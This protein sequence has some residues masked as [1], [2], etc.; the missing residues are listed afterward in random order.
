[1]IIWLRTLIAITTVSLVASS[2]GFAVG[3]GPI[4]KN[5]RPSSIP[6][7]SNNSYH[8]KAKV[9]D[10]AT[11]MSFSSNDLTWSEKNVTHVQ[12][13]PSWRLE[14]GSYIWEP[15]G[16]NQFIKIPLQEQKSTKNIPSDKLE[17]IQIEYQDL[18]LENPSLPSVNIITTKSKSPS[19]LNKKNFSRKNIFSYNPFISDNDYLNVS[20]SLWKKK[21]PLYLIKRTL[22]LSFDD[23][24]H[25][26]TDKHYS[27]FQRRFQKDLQSIE[28]IDLVVNKQV[29]GE[30]SE[31]IFK[32]ISCNFRLSYNNAMFMQVIT[33]H[34][35]N[36]IVFKSNDKIIIR[37][38]IGD[39]LRQ[40]NKAP[41]TA[42]LKEMIIF[43]PKSL[44]YVRHYRPVESIVFQH[45][46]QD[47]TKDL[48]RFFKNKDK[49]TK[50]S[51][52]LIHHNE[53][54][55]TP[56]QITPFADQ[57][58]R[59]QT[60]SRDSKRIIVKLPNIIPSTGKSFQY[61]KTKLSNISLK[62]KPNNPD[63]KSGFRL[64]RV[65][66]IIRNEKE[67]K[68]IFIVDNKK[69]RRWGGPFLNP[70]VNDKKFERIQINSFFPFENF[71]KSNPY[72]SNEETRSGISVQTSDNSFFRLLDS[73]EGL[74]C[75][76]W[77]FSKNSVATIKFPEIGPYN[78]NQNITL[79][80]DLKGPLQVNILDSP[81]T[82]TNTSSKMQFLL[83]K[84]R[85][86]ALIVK[87]DKSDFKGH[88]RGV[89]GRLVL[90][91][92]QKHD[93]VDP[94]LSDIFK[95][96]SNSSQKIL[97][98]ARLNLKIIFSPNKVSSD[99]H[100]FFNRFI[101]SELKFIPKQVTDKLF[102]KKFI[103]SRGVTVQ[104]KES[105][106]QWRTLINGLELEGKGK[107]IEVDWPV[108]A[109]LKEETHFHLGVTKGSDSIVS[110]KVIPFSGAN[111]LA[112][113]STMPNQSLPLNLAG[114]NVDRFKLHLKLVENRPFKIVLREMALFEPVMAN[115]AQAINVHTQWNG[116]VLTPYQ[117]NSKMASTILIKGRHLHATV[118]P[119]QGRSG[120]VQW[121]TQIDQKSHA[122]SWLKTKY[123]IPPSAHAFNPCWLKV[124]WVGKNK[125]MPQTICTNHFEG[126]LL[127]PVN[128][129]FT[130]D[131][132]E[133]IHWE[134]RI[135]LPQTQLPLPVS[136]DLEV[137]SHES[138]ETTSHYK[139][140]NFPLLKIRG[141]E[142]FPISLTNTTLD[143]GIHKINIDTFG[144]KKF[145]FLKNPYLHID[146]FS[147]Q[148]TNPHGKTTL[149][150][151]W[152]PTII[153]DPASNF[154]SINQTLKFLLLLL[155][156]SLLTWWLL[157]KKR[158]TIA[159]NRVEEN[160]ILIK[161]YGQQFIFFTKKITS[162]IQSRATLYNRLFG[163][164]LII[165]IGGMILSG[166]VKAE[167]IIFTSSSFLFLGVLC[168]EF[169]D[170]K[171]GKIPVI[172]YILSSIMFLWLLWLLAHSNQLTS[173]FLIPLL[174]L[175][176]FYIP[177]L[178]R[179]VA[180]LPHYQTQPAR[181]WIIIAGVTYF[182]GIIA[183]VCGAGFDSFLRILSV[184]HLA[185]VPYWGHLM[186]NIQTMV[187]DRSQSI[188]EVVYG[189]QENLYVTGFFVFLIAIA[190]LRFFELTIIT[191]Q[192]A[193][194]GFYL[195]VTG[196]ALKTKKLFKRKITE[197]NI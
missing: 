106:T 108:E 97:C 59:V 171:N 68:S 63:F 128:D 55:K 113:F 37:F 24:W 116:S 154:S 89:R 31:E 176:Y 12:E 52:I 197:Q 20:S 42:Y 66:K 177:W 111:R 151:V 150:Y 146:F 122:I 76:F 56:N 169:C 168:H 16:D 10:N 174:S 105:F 100:K 121:R 32:K 193:I 158:W 8:I 155:A 28:A 36:P 104:A 45:R 4:S 57:I 51:S 44:P 120:T 19:H 43:V 192:F 127:I 144:T 3:G 132:L 82:W 39:F 145:S 195:L 190:F 124:T 27:V 131:F 88:H 194:I 60:M 103:H 67:I 93:S 33:H 137:V 22:G 9:S 167:Y 160:S 17:E 62:F 141:E 175:A 91:T 78:T 81:V 188:A 135:G 134:A 96:Q 35:L 74:V 148:N 123:R 161:K 107:W 14:N 99:C 166:N 102:R 83:K 109:F 186:K 2:A 86:P 181:F 50:V 58:M 101:S 41:Q 189:A 143:L 112:S 84:G 73:E 136:F 29:M 7:A 98:E 156:I 138:N 6:S 65:R 40:H 173:R 126:R 185:I 191:E 75:D 1:M 178:S 149:E 163:F 26:S 164:T 115:E 21:K 79:N 15:G 147:F 117:P 165:L 94:L 129:S 13:N 54:L 46:N 119:E 87:A 38:T 170:T 142:I 49:Q 92:I 139:S 11:L 110:I 95:N 184:G 70:N 85:L 72:K 5:H 152:K 25:Y 64:Q 18:F 179:V 71:D 159:G 196:I 125:K 114:Q 153:P 187:E 48:V 172:V 53:T 80:W 162:F 90:K 118:L 180:S 61:E 30:E 34:K 77:F 133:F 69:L 157:S 130:D 23:H 182:I 47:E 183:L 140:S